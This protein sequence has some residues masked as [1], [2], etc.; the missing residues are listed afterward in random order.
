M[1]GSTLHNR[2][3]VDAEL[4]RGGMGTVYR[5]HDIVLDRPVAIKVLSDS[6]LGTEG[7]ARLLNEARAVAKLDH[8]NIVAVHDAGETAGTPFIVMQLVEGE[9][10]H[11]RRLTNLD[12]II[13]IAGQVCA[14]LEHAHAHGIIHRDLKPENVI[15][16]PN[17]LAKLMDFG[18]ARSSASRLTSE[19]VFIGTVFYLAPEQALGREIDHRVDLYSLGVILYELA[20]GRL[21]FVADDPVAVISQHLHAPVVPPSTYNPEISPALDALIGKLLA[22][23]PAHRFASALEVRQALE[24]LD[25]RSPANQAAEEASPIERIAR[26]RLVARERELLE[27][28]YVESDLARYG[29]SRDQRPDTK[30]VNLEVTVTHD[31]GVP[32][33]YQ[34]LPGNTADITRPAPHLRALLRFLAR[35]E[36]A[37]RQWRPLLIGDCKMMTS[38]VV[39]VCHQHDLFY[40]PKFRPK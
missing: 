8:P 13:A 20:A 33:L 21:P 18:L 36:L 39:A 6:G 32:V 31:G 38:E 40:L 4:G 30:Q 29:Y 28:A 1:L 27:G 35:P 11:A 37:D 5:A 34:T 16:T 2:Y 15:I 7:R 25:S 14:A 9:S 19:G 17:S 3:R 10:L 23:D 26:G 24:D 22:K 12:E